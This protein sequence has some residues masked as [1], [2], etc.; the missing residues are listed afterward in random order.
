MGRP[1]RVLMVEDSENDVR[2]IVRRLQL[3][4]VLPV[5]KQ[6]CTAEEMRSA[7]KATFLL[8]RFRAKR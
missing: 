1:L 2:V 5:F 3:G 6:V 7:P 8:N 4:G